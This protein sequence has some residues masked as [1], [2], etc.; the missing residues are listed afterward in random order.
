MKKYIILLLSIICI[1]CTKESSSAAIGDSSQDEYYVKYISEKAIGIISY[2]KED[3][4]TFTLTQNY[5]QSFERTI[6]PVSKGF[7]C[8]FSVDR[9]TGVRDIPVRIEVKKNEAPFVVKE[10]GICTISYTIDF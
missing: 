1:A 4:T 6:G 2:T 10:E 8:N 9:G 3:G 5:N 7:K